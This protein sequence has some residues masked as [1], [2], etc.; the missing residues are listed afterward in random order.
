M[1]CKFQP[2]HDATNVSLKEL[3]QEILENLKLFNMEPEA[4]FFIWVKILKNIIVQRKWSNTIIQRGA[5]GHEIWIHRE[6]CY[7]VFARM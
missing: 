7:C 3:K 1:G 4:R 5:D 6:E 2:R